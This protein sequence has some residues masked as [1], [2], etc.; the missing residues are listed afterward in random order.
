[1]TLVRFNNP[2]SRSYNNHSLVNLLFNHQ[3]DANCF[4]NNHCEKPAAN[5]YETSNA[6]TIDLLIPGFSKD[7]V[8]VVV[9]DNLLIVS[10]G[11]RKEEKSERKVRRIE[12]G[13]RNFERRFKL[14]EKI[15]AD[16][17]RAEF[18]NGVLTIVLPLKP[19]DS[20]KS[21]REIEIQ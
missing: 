20:R 5:V 7:E 13:K 8:K 9:D 15:D 10:G 4:E 18:N 11:A 14:S 16:A 12:F 19:E 6:Y 17:V 3:L 21:T 1:M 2:V